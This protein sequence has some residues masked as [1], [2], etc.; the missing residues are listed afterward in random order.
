MHFANRK[1]GKASKE[2][3]GSSNFESF[4][5]FVSDFKPVVN[6]VA[7]YPHNLIFR[8]QKPGVFFLR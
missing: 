5:C 6:A 8:K 1:N 2:G 3:L 4:A 7:N